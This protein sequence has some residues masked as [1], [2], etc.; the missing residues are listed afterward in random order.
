MPQSSVL[1]I[2]AAP[3]G[4][5]IEFILENRSLRRASFVPASSRVDR[6]YLEKQHEATN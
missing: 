6:D 2:A 5:V 3:E 1:F 4:T